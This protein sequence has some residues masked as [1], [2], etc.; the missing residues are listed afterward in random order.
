MIWKIVA[1]LVLG[2]FFGGWNGAI[3]I[4][5]ARM[6]EDIREKGSGNAGLTNFLRNYGGLQTLLV[7]A[8]DFGKTVAACLIAQ[9]ILPQNPLLSTALAGFA[10]Q[11]GHIFPPL[12]QFHG[13]KGVLCSAAVALM[14]DWRIFLIAITLFVLLFFITRYVS[15]ASIL[16]M[17]T[18]GGLTVAFYHD[19]PEAWGIIVA[20][21]TV[22]VLM[23]TGNIKRLLQGKERKTYFHKYKNER[24]NH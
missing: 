16:S 6:G 1:C 19:R 12:Y 15:L 9:L 3:L 8:I 20:M 24:E 23:H 11:L 13:G 17:V 10:V 18:F 22:V 2:F 5:R 21:T 7:V 4:S 14:I